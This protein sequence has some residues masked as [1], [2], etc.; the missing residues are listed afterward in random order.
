MYKTAPKS[1][2][3]VAEELE[4]RYVEISLL[5]ETQMWGMS[6]IVDADEW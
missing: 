4:A 3:A 6:R 2:R 5:T 1:S